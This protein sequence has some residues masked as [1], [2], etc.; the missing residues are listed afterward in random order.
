M[1]DMFEDRDPPPEYSASS[2]IEVR[3]LWTALPSDKNL[4]ENG[5]LAFVKG[6]SSTLT[7]AVQAGFYTAKENILKKAAAEQQKQA[8][9]VSR[10]ASHPS[11]SSSMG[12]NSL[13][14]SILQG[15]MWLSWGRR[16][17]S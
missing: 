16:V 17:P 10:G 6:G 1:A 5:I 12:D 15:G 3:L 2:T 13:D 11:N 14:E 8:D 7:A 9:N 4:Q